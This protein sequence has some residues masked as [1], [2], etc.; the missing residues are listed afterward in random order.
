LILLFF[1]NNG[2]VSAVADTQSSTST[3]PPTAGTLTCFV[4]SSIFDCV[5]I[6]PYTVRWNVIGNP[7][8]N[9]SITGLFSVQYPNGPV[10]VTAHWNYPL[11]VSINNI[12]TNP[13]GQYG[14]VGASGVYINNGGSGSVCSH[15]PGQLC[16][17]YPIGT[18]NFMQNAF[19]ESNGKARVG[20]QQV[21]TPL[22]T[23]FWTPQ[24]A[25]IIVSSVAYGGLPTN[26]PTIAPTSTRT[27]TPTR[28]PT[29]T[30]TPTPTRT[31]TPTRTPTRTPTVTPMPNN[32]GSGNCWQSGPS[33][34]SYV[35]YY[36]I[37]SS[38]PPS[39][40]PSIEA[41][42]QTWNN[43]TP[44]HFT[45]VRQTGSSNTI[46]NEVP[47]NSA[48]IAGTNASPATGPYT[49]A[50]TKLNPNKTWD[51]NNSSPSSTAFNVQNVMTLNLDIGSIFMILML[52]VVT[53]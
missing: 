47:L 33:W 41:A 38:I 5:Q 53:M 43:V 19:I 40:I 18:W 9:G 44:S 12:Q 16:G 39:W 34:P 28:T 20:F 21:P 10:Y 8:D 13:K 4:D 48:D 25:Y 45:F 1:N 11:W 46:R 35:V 14:I 52:Q 17:N 32:H 50:Y 26:T 3:P 27:L 7:Y 30:R 49:S 6:D 29:R 42:A 24:E 31:A 22:T 51:I 15:D 2:V 23:V 37:D 36:D